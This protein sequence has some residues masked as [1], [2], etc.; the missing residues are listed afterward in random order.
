MADNSRLDCRAGAGEQGAKGS[1]ERVGETS[2]AKMMESVTLRNRAVKSRLAEQLLEMGL[3]RKS[4]MR[5][6]NI[7]PFET[8]DQPSKSAQ[9]SIDD[10]KRR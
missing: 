9:R 6:L 3:T 7:D 2:E 5:L 8:I 10:S 4:V 1:L